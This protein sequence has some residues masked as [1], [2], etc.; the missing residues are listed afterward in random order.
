MIFNIIY[1]CPNITK[2]PP[3]EYN[4]KDKIEYLYGKGL[5]AT[6]EGKQAIKDAD[7]SV[8]Y[9]I[10][11]FGEVLKVDITP[12]N[13]P[14]LYDLLITIYNKHQFCHYQMSKIFFK[15][16]PYVYMKED[17]AVKKDEENLRKVS[18]YPSGQAQLGYIF[19]SILSKISP[20]DADKLYQRGLDYGEARVITGYHWQSDVELSREIAKMF[21]QSL[22]QQ[23]EFQKWLKVAKKEFDFKK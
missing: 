18:S 13:T 14:I 1:T 20:E 15:E 5:R 4:V 7:W 11:I 2:M 12:K 9:L 8:E 6:E 23:E 16:R 19:G 21:L 3:L 22:Y 17:S 10:K